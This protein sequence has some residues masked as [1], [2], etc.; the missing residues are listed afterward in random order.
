M[1]IPAHSVGTAHVP[2]G[3]L[4]A[5]FAP[6][7][8][9][10]SSPAHLHLFCTQRKKRRGREFLL[11]QLPSHGPPN[12]I[13]TARFH[14]TCFSFFAAPPPLQVLSVLDYKKTGYVDLGMLL[15]LLV[16]VW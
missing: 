8:V 12:G 4:P 15:M 14:L 16:S 1:K 7:C 3:Q 6:P 5:C 11:P 13:P 2:G 10:A 9:A